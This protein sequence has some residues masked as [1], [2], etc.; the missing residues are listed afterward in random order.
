M[1][2]GARMEIDGRIFESGMTL[3]ENAAWR[4]AMPR[5]AHKR[6]ET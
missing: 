4:M 2:H 1:Q 6:S 5:A 3:S